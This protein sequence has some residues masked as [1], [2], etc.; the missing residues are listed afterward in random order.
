MLLST[1]KQSTKMRDQYVV[2]PELSY[3][4]LTQEKPLPAAISRVEAFSR[5]T[6]DSAGTTDSVRLQGGC[7]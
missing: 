1:E 7:E 6:R 2:C 5:T 3:R 4:K